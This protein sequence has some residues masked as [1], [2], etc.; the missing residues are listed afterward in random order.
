MQSA[1][2]GMGG[3][4]ESWVGEPAATLAQAAARL[5][6]IGQVRRRSSL[7]LTAP[8]GYADQPQFMNAVVE[9]VT[10]FGP[11]ELL[12]ALLE[13]ETEF[14]RDRS[15]AIVNGPRTLDL[16]LLLY[17]DIVMSAA[18]LVLP[19]PR[20]SE[21]AFVLAPLCEIAPQLAIPPSG[22]SAAELFAALNIEEGSVARIES[23]SWNAS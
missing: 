1:Y 23:K 16:D 17:G 8:V 10:E 9:L 22:R 4:L 5:G 14:G 15:Q 6:E 21:R 12:C 18:G 3:N 7:Y 2:I 19:H 20:L 13:I 11:W